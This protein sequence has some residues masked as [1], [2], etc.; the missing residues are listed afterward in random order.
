MIKTRAPDGANKS[1]YYPCLDLGAS[2]PLFNSQHKSILGL[3]WGMGGKLP[4]NFKTAKDSTS[5]DLYCY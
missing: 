3:W 1:A 4:P 2:R 5:V